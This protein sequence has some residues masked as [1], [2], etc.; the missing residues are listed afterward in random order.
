M[1]ALLLFVLFER[2]QVWSLF[3]IEKKGVLV[4]EHYF[5]FQKANS[6][7]SFSDASRRQTSTYCREYHA[8]RI[9]PGW[10]FGLRKWP[11]AHALL[12]L[13]DKN[14]HERELH[15]ST[16]AIHVHDVMKYNRLSSPLSALQPLPR[17]V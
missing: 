10:T 11:P 2:W 7:E 4:R 13:G 8:N 1:R 5:D 15:P 16:G 14:I 3:S 6:I 9:L 12:K 17:F